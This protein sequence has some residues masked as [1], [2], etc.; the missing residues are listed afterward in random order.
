MVDDG[1][2]WWNVWL[3]FGIVRIGYGQSETDY[4]KMNFRWDET[5]FPNFANKKEID[6]W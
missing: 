3:N 2:W 5:N 1:R 6:S 4:L